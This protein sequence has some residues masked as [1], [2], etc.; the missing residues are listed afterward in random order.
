M[1]TFSLCTLTSSSGTSLT[2]RS[3]ALSSS[4]AVFLMNSLTS[5]SSSISGLNPFCL[6]SHAMS[7]RKASS[8]CEV[9]AC[10]VSLS[11]FSRASVLFP[12]SSAAL[13]CSPA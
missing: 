12:Y 10:R 5:S 3:T 6:Y 7:G 9:S 4:A 11:S 8:T 1:L 13:S 2:E